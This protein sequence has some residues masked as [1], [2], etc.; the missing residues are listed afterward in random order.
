MSNI[1]RR[2]RVLRKY[3]ALGDTLDELLQYNADHFV[4]ATAVTPRCLPLTDEE[5]VSSWVEY[6]KNAEKHKVF[7]FL[8]G[9]LTQL[10]F[11]I[12]K[13]ISTTADYI[14]VNKRGELAE[15]VGSATGLVLEQPGQLTLQI[16]Q[17]DAGKI[18]IL[19]TPHRNDFVSLVRALTMRNEPLTVPESMG[20]C[21]VS[22]YNNW[23]RI[24][25]YRTA[26]ER[27]TMAAG[28]RASLK[29]L[30]SEWKGEFLRL[31][32]QK[33]LYQD[34][35]LLLTAGYYSGVPPAALR[36]SDEEW[37]AKSLVIRREHECSH[38]FTRRVF[39]SMRNHLLD[40]LIADYI[41]VVA[42]FGRF[43]AEWVLY[44]MG[45][46]HFPAYRRG[47]RLENYCGNP[48]LSEAA[49]R[50]LQAIFVSAAESLERFT[51][52]CADL[53][54]RRYFRPLMITA[55]T[56][57]T[58]EELADAE[59]EERLTHNLQRLLNRF[60]TERCVEAS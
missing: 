28:S 46:E 35:F 23:D 41:G 51:D 27:G 20:A 7:D 54:T 50:I 42:A 38:Y 1:E 6:A 37:R 17:T 18:P 25:A 33:H 15:T 30:D 39:S 2:I 10:N 4:A 13:G 3:G 36:L 47:G 12:Q 40:E 45:L 16:Y 44:F 52:H 19:Y 34:R 49:L 11:P 21:A 8:K 43:R 5:F 48:P 32:P 26:W 9:R 58:L 59:S 53:L 24:R 22:G 31:I 29:S 14:A 55:L 56:K 60:E 57:L